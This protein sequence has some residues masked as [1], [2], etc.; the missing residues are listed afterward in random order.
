[1]AHV[2]H[3]AFDPQDSRTLFLAIEQGA[4]LKSVDGGES[5]RELSA[6]YSLDDEIYKDIHRVVPHPSI[7]RAV[8]FTGGEGLYR[9]SDGGE[10]WEHLTTRSHRIGYPDALLVSPF[11]DDVMFMAGARKDPGTWRESHWADA[12]V[13]R[14]R[15]GGTSWDILDSGLPEQMRANIEAMSMYGWDNRFDLFVGTTDGEVYWSQDQG[16]RWVC[17]ADGLAPVSKSGH[18]RNLR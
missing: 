10:S 8:Y 1:V 5:W 7:P 15:D 6:Y 16:E 9:S 4:L 14:S 13:A 17:I 18:Y 2:K 12:T 3:I 11:E